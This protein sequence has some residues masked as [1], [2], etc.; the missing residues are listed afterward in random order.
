MNINSAWDFLLTLGLYL[1]D[2]IKESWIKAASGL[3]P[4]NA[5]LFFAG[6]AGIVYLIAAVIF[7]MVLL[8]DGFSVKSGRN[9]KIL[10]A[11]GVIFIISL[12]K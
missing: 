8:C 6:L 11:L 9:F 7:L 3:D 4:W 1:I 12:I 10:I 5:K 2:R